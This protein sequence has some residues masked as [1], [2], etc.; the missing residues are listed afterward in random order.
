MEKLKW[1][2]MR[3]R[4]MAET[5][6]RS[7][8]LAEAKDMLRKAFCGLGEACYAGDAMGIAR[9]REEIDALQTRMNVLAEAIDELRN[10]RRCMRCGRVQ[11]NE[12]RYCT[13]CGAILKTKEAE[14]LW[15]ETAAASQE[16]NTPGE[17]S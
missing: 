16:E 15:P 2:G 14:I 8:E 3:A 7:A 11:S 12:N 9:K 13:Q 6:K 4:T 5:A 1:A 17:E 10:E